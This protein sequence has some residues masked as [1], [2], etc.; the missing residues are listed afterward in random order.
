MST[1]IAP[2]FI[3]RLFGSGREE[4]AGASTL[5]LRYASAA[6]DEAIER[7]AQLDSRRQPR[8]AVLVAEVR[9]ELWAAHSLEDG[10][11]VADP[12]RPTRALVALLVQR[13]RQLRRAESAHRAAKPR[14]RAGYDHPAWN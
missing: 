8:G 6:D 4:P 3:K 5:T 10:Q 12:F 7:L 14:I 9:G 2:T 11:T 1:T 13:A